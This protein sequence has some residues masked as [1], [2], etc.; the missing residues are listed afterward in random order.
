MGEELNAQGRRAFAERR[1]CVV[2]EKCGPAV[3]VTVAEE[4]VVSG[5]WDREKLLAERPAQTVADGG[6][7]VVIGSRSALGMEFP[8]IAGARW[9]ASSNIFWKCTT[10]A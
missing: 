10:G 2:A 7:A 1:T 6:I 4:R 5:M 3:A 8:D 9:T